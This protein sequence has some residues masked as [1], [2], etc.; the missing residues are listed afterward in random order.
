[1]NVWSAF[2][3]PDERTLGAIAAFRR[4]RSL[5]RTSP[6]SLLL[7]SHRIS[8]SE[9]LCYTAELWLPMALL[10]SDVLSEPDTLLPLTCSLLTGAPTFSSFLLHSWVPTGAGNLLSS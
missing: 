5:H 6:N 4:R 3:L 9:E 2:C 7:S 10:S 1:M 8:K